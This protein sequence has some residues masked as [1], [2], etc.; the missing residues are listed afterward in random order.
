MAAEIPPSWL[1]PDSV[2]LTDRVAVVT[3]A[4]AGIGKGVAL[5]MARFGADVAICDRDPE[6]PE[7][8]LDGPEAHRPAQSLGQ[9]RLDAI[10][11]AVDVDDSR[12]QQHGGRHQRRRDGQEDDQ[13]ATRA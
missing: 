11:V 5:A 3:G 10:A 6:R 7:R 4:G 9:G 2:L 12:Q 8:Q 13:L 1:T